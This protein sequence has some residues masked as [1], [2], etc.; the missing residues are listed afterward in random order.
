[1]VKS[2]RVKGMMEVLIKVVR[3]YR[4]T[5]MMREMELK[6]ERDVLEIKEMVT[7]FKPVGVIVL[8]VS[9]S[10]MLT[11]CQGS[12]TLIKKNNRFQFHIES[13]GGS[14]FWSM[15]R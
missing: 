15:L 11:Q 7:G 1:M 13:E 14:G 9:S 5:R 3:S 12:M 6:H 2:S 4:S 8:S 10:G